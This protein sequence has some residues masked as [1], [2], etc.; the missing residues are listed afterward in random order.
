MLVAKGADVAE[1][2]HLACYSFSTLIF[3]RCKEHSDGRH[4][5]RFLNFFTLYSSF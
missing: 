4:P 1:E 2:I 5:Q 3:F